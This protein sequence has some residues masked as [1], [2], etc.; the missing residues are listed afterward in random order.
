MG[1]VENIKKQVDLSQYKGI[2]KVVLAY[3]GGVDTSIMIKLF[4]DVCGFEVIAVT[5]DL[6]QKEYSNVD[7]KSIKEKAEKLGAKHYFI[8]AKEDF[9]KNYAWK[10]VQANCLYQGAYPNSTALA[11]PLISKHLVEVAKKEGAG[12]VAH[13][14]TGK[15]NDQVRFDVSVAA[16]DSSIKIIAPVRDW[17]LNRDEEIAYAQ[18]KNIWIPVKKDS[19]YSIDANLWGRSIECGVLEDPATEPPEDAFEWVKVPEKARDKPEVVKITFKK[20]VPVEIECADG[21]TTGAVE[22]VDKMNEVAGRNGIG[23]ID[24]MEDRVVGLKSRENYECPAAIA[25]IAAHTD[26]EKYVFTREENDFKPYVTK[27]W[28]DL[29]YRGLWYSPLMKSLNAY[30]E[31]SQEYVDGWVKLKLYKGSMRVIGR[32]SEHAL[33]DKLLATYDKGTTFNQKDA[34][35]FIKLWGLNTVMAN[36]VRK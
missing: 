20:G 26:L 27:T 29:V 32:Y 14:S 9:I 15:G 31:T 35:G 30:L 2:K 33:Y 36:K 23:L 13:G 6:G 10:G 19:P 28:G 3:S 7:K 17:L 24:H 5:L 12:A 4:Q 34:I 18:Q 21:K 22:M 8:D 1:L 16:L 11:R 25:F